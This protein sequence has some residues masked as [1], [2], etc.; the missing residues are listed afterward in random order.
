MSTENVVYINPAQCRGAR[1][2][3]GMTQPALADAAKLGLSTIVDFE[4]SRRPVS[5]LAVKTI[6]KALEA[7]GIEFIP[8]NGGGPGVR[9]RKS[10]RPKRSK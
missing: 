5:T 9:L 7:A 4:R 10:P 3:L 1:A 2:L 8:E 6:L